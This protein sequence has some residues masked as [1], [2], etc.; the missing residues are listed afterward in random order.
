[1]QGILWGKNQSGRGMR[2]VYLVQVNNRF[3]DNV[4]LP[5]SVGLIQAYCQSLDWV[6]K[7]YCFK[8]LIYLRERSDAIVERMENPDVVGFSCYMWNWEFNKVLAQ[9]VRESYPDCLI[10]FGGPHVPK[11]VA[12]RRDIPDYVDVVVHHEGEIAFSEILLVRCSGLKAET[13]VHRSGSRI[14]DLSILPSPY[15]T[16]VFDMMLEADYNHNAS[17]ETHR[18]CVYSCSFCLTG[19]AVIMTDAGSVPI[20]EVVLD[21]VG[22]QVWTHTGL[23]QILHRYE[24]RYSGVIKRVKVVGRPLIQCT[25]NHEWLT[26][27]GWISAGEITVG[28]RIRVSVPD[29]QRAGVEILDLCN[30]L[31]A[32]CV[33]GMFVKFKRGKVKVPRYVIMNN[34]FMRLCGLY[35]AEGHVSFSKTRPNSGVVGWT[36]GKHETDLITETCQLV[37]LCLGV[38]PIVSETD[39][40][41]QI[42]VCSSVYA[43]LFSKLFGSGSLRKKIPYAWFSVSSELI[44]AFIRGYFDGDGCFS[45]DKKNSQGRCIASTVSLT[46]ATQLQVL[47]SLLGICAGVS[48]R[49]LL[50]P[51]IC[52]RDV[53]VHES[54]RIEFAGRFP[55]KLPINLWAYVTSVS[56]ADFSGYVFNLEVE[57]TP[58]YS[59]F[60]LE[61]H[62]C[63]WGSAV[64]TK[65]RAFDDERLVREFEW[66]GQHEIELLYNCDANFGLLPRDLELTKEMVAAKEKYGYPRQFR[67]AYAKNSNQKV[68][69]ISSVVHQAGM[70]KGTTLSFQSLDAHTL[71]EI[72][73]SN[74]KIE[75]FKSLLGTYR[76]EGIPT[77]TEL[78]LGLPGETYDSFTRGIEQLLK[79]GQHEGLNIYLLAVLPNA[80]MGDL[81]YQKKHG[82]RV[83]QSPLLQQH[84]TPNQD[85][86]QETCLLCIETATMP[87]AD[88]VQAYMFSWA[89]QTFHGFGLLREVAMYLHDVQGVSYREF[90]E[91]LL[92]VAS[93]RPATLLAEEYRRTIA[94]VKRGLDGGQWGEVDLRYGNIIWPTEEFTYLNIASQKSSRFYEEM[95]LLLR[96]QWPDLVDVLL[97]LAWDRVLVRTADEF[98]GNLEEFAKQAVW[99]ARK[100]LLQKPVEVV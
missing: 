82:M 79:A 78:I 98:G 24:R 60:G 29:T 49:K 83:I 61:S 27:R 35:V 43:R 74:I 10:V 91:W 36:F 54:Y 64:L 86:I 66:M 67:A 81:E 44:H 100:R 87:E 63:D 42:Y 5:Y 77:Y 45:I 34:L 48:K 23:K 9:K 53:N 12:L 4:F 57:D 52:G 2:N 22:E 18:G 15:V 69:D 90:Y 58:I 92:Q 25:P 95:N 39:T 46:L 41:M 30:Y 93:R 80:E 1:M 76:Q 11:S 50:V 94:I 38:E 72:K 59:V 62:N 84:S 21:K 75:N 89:V 70:S 8:E 55:E 32:L 6:N 14:A 47:L 37:R 51:R 99:Y 85:G 31:D 33:D 13:L 40:G 97:R 3:G 88:W 28:D 19:D 17:Q 26:Q 7:E 56:D 20:S 16:G 65:I 73:R 68:L 96:L 71:Q